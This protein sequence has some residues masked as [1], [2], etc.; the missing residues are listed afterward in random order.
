MKTRCAKSDE[1]SAIKLFELIKRH[2]N[3]KPVAKNSEI[4][5]FIITSFLINT[6][7]IFRMQEKTIG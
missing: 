2:A 5:R 1:V 7:A 4:L 3:K 6:A